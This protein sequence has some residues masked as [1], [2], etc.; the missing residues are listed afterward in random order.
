MEYWNKRFL[1]EGKIWGLLPSKT[2]IHA[3][4]LFQSYNI[5]KVLIPGMG[6]GRNSKV[7]SSQNF[8]VSGVEISDIACTMAK[9]YDPNTRIFKGSVLD[10]PF[11]KEIYDAIYCYN[12]LHLFFRSERVLFLKKCYDQ[13]KEEGLIYFAVFSDKEKTYGKGKSVE[14]DTFESKPCRPVHYFSEQDLIE[15]FKDFLIIETGIVTDEEEHGAEGMHVHVLRYIFGQRTK[16]Y[17]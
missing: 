7:F 17:K 11:T 1:N 16:I 4:E 9:E 2:A 8:V 3:L 14:K 15:H 10:M 5:K 12:L 13:L 6:Y